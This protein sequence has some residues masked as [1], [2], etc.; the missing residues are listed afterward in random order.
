MW[1]IC[2]NYWGEASS[3]YAKCIERV[4]SNPKEKGSETLKSSLPLAATRLLAARA[5]QLKWVEY[6]YG[7]I[8]ED[9]WRGLG[10]PYLAA[11]AAGYATQP[12]QIYPCLLYTSRCV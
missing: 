6:R 1:S 10:Q 4:K 2:Y 11:E 8:G 12:V 7:P 3:L 5:A 9:L